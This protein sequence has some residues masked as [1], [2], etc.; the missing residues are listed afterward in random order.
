MRTDIWLGRPVATATGERLSTRIAI[1]RLTSKVR[2]ELRVRDGF[3]HETRSMAALTDSEVIMYELRMMTFKPKTLAAIIDASENPE[4]NVGKS[5]GVGPESPKR[6]ERIIRETALAFS[7]LHDADI[8]PSE[9]G[10]ALHVLH[11]MTGY[12]DVT[13]MLTLVPEQVRALLTIF[14]HFSPDTADRAM[15]NPVMRRMVLANPD[16]ASD[17]VQFATQRGIK[18]FSDVN[19]TDFTATVGKY[20]SPSMVGAP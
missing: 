17:V 6:S 14:R 2:H 16:I 1:D 20:Q 3:K 19:A 5:M 11:V 13:V 8:H 4:Y 7:F 9:Y 15:F 18:R 12:K 10:D